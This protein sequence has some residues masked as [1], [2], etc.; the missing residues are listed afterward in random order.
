M[1]MGIQTTT[2]IREI[3]TIKPPDPGREKLKLD[4]RAMVMRAEKIRTL[5]NSPFSYVLNYLSMG[6]RTKN[7]GGGP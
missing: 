7:Q 4:K 5:E 1:L 6:Y 3:S 2:K